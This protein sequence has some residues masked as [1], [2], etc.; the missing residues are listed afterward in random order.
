MSADTVTCDAC[1]LPPHGEAAAFAPGEL[2]KGW[3]IRVFGRR[4]FRLCD[5]CGSIR[6]FKGGVS[7]YLQEALGLAPN[8]MCDFAASNE[9]GSGLHRLRIRAA[10]SGLEPGASA[11]PDA[12]HRDPASD[13][14]KR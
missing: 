2:P 6:H 1:G 10:A 13:G 3:H 14:V 8:A 12:E 7:A 9:P 11:E 4:R 5:C